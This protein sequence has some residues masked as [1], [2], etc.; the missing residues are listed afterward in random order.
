MSR[1]SSRAEGELAESRSPPSHVTIHWL[2]PVCGR[3]FS[4]LGHLCFNVSISRRGVRSCSSDLGLAACP[5]GVAE[6]R[7]SLSVA[8]LSRR[9]SRRQQGTA[10]PYAAGAAPNR[11]EAP[12]RF[13]RPM[14]IDANGR[15]L[16]IGHGFCKFD[17]NR[18]AHNLSPKRCAVAGAAHRRA[19]DE[20]HR[21]T[22]GSPI[23]PR[24]WHR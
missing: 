20:H 4:R 3:A 21:P 6:P 22:P 9:W 10:F 8:G 19:R 2:C 1:G 12:T 18:R 23:R 14:R 13:A 24:W 15:G 16:D 7:I 11:C 5:R 17:R